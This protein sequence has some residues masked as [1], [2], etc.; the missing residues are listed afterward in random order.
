MNMGMKPRHLVLAA[1]G[2]G[3]LYALGVSA[4]TLIFVVALAYMASMHLGHRGGHGGDGGQL[5]SKLSSR[6]PGKQ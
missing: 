4:G 2:V 1:V 6:R 5:P 3:A